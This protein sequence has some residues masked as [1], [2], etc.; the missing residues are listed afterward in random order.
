MEK[1]EATQ[2]DD[3]MSEKFSFSEHRSIMGSV[4]RIETGE[5]GKGHNNDRS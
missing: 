2:I 5:T 1:Y 4:A 3:T